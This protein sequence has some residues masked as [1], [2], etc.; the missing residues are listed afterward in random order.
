MSLPRTLA[1][2]CLLLVLA[3]VGTAAGADQPLAPGITPG[4]E[5]PAAIA[6]PAAYRFQWD[7]YVS[8]VVIGD[9]AVSPQALR[10]PAW[11]VTY[12]H[13]GAVVVGYCATA[14]RDRVGNLH[15]D[16]RKAFIT[17]PQ[18]ENWSPDSFAITREGQVLSIDDR[19]SANG[20]KV[21]EITEAVAGEVYRTLLHIAMA[22][23]SEMS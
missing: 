4:R 19:N 18:R 20:G 3:L 10:R 15:I 8:L 21:I 1:V 9:T 6:A 22:I 16:A 5:P 14:Y 13:A 11:V 7:E 17:G 2:A 23:V 12:D